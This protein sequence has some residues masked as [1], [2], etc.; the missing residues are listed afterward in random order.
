MGVEAGLVSSAATSSEGDWAENALSLF[1]HEPRS[2]CDHRGFRTVICAR[3]A[4]YEAIAL[5][6][7]VC[8]ED[9]KSVVVEAYEAWVRENCFFYVVQR[10]LSGV[11]P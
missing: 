9:D 8:L 10:A 1:G 7:K 11:R 6:R 5:G 4:N 3:L 2:I